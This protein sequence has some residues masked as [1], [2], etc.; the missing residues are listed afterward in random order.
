MEDDLQLTW[1]ALQAWAHDESLLAPRGFHRGFVRVEHAQW[2][3]AIM[4]FDQERTVS[5]SASNCGVLQIAASGEH[6]YTHFSGNTTAHFVHLD[7]SYMAMWLATRQQVA[8]WLPAPEWSSDTNGLTG[9]IREDAAWNLYNI[10]SR[11]FKKGKDGFQRSLVVPY[12]PNTY[13]IAHI[14][15]L[16]HLSNNYCNRESAAAEATQLFCRIR[17]EDLLGI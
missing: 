15:M 12:D 11:Q 9:G 10:E 13:T 5:I 8:E 16:P 4:A 7:N 14:A 2:D 3:G 6:E 1:A 17:F